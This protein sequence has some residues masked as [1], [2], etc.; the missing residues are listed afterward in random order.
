MSRS[1]LV[2]KEFPL[3]KEWTVSPTEL[4][5]LQN[6]QP[7]LHED[8]KIKKL[9]IAPTTIREL[10]IQFDKETLLFPELWWPNFF[11]RKR[12][13]RVRKNQKNLTPIEWQRFI[14]AIETLA[15][16]DI[17]SPT[18]SEFVQIHVDAMTTHHGH[19]WG[20]HRAI[21]FLAWHREYLAKLEAR[22]VT[23]NPL[24]TLPYW[25]W[26]T[27][28]SAIPAPLNNQE[29]LADWGVTRAGNFNG[30]SLASASQLNELLA[31][32]DFTSF[33]S[34]L[35]S[36]PFHDR[37]HVLVGGTMAT[38]GS[39]ADPLFWLHHAFIDKIWADWQALHPNVSQ[40][41]I[42]DAL[43]PTP[44]MTRTV[45]QVLNIRALGYIYQ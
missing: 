4:L 18:Y 33:Q 26:I 23:I 45:A 41:N 34:R 6:L 17:P 19:S 36:A 32:A 9:R 27:D 42:S 44:I 24:V 25:D 5:E 12:Q 28:R 13:Y 20:A 37:L 22:L 1:R 3:V 43:Q 29:I 30:N 11:C 7:P 10:P 38:A 21:N 15:V 8:F 2:E 35:E 40:T 39:P 14:H 31:I 16:N